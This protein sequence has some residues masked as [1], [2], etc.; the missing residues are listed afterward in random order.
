M[1]SKWNE[2]QL[3]AIE[4][5]DNNTLVSASAGSG[6]TAV[7]IE[8]IICGSGNAVFACSGHTVFPFR[9]EPADT[10]ISGIRQPASESMFLQYLVLAEI[11]DNGASS[12]DGGP[13][14][15][16]FIVFQP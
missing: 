1:K 2:D 13:S 8:R 16:I 11:F 9:A 12:G 14:V 7:T 5:V 6:K 4:S 15:D 10:K 3:K